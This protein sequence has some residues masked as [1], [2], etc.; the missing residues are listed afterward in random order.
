MS[1][2]R[3]AHLRPQHRCEPLQLVNWL[4]VSG[5]ATLPPMAP[6][7][8]Q[9]LPPLGP[10]RQTR[11]PPEEPCALVFP[12]P[13]PISRRPP[14]R[15][16]VGASPLAPARGP[17]AGAG[18]LVAVGAPAGGDQALASVRGLHARGELD[19][20]ASAVQPDLLGHLRPGVQ[21]LWPP[22]LAG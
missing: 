7:V 19:R 4:R 12:R 18:M 2:E 20:R 6:G 22:P 3:V 1:L 9:H 17:L 10:R 13:G 11:Q 5:P 14:G 15:P 8:R 21:R 16:G